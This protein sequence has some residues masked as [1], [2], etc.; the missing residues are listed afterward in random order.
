MI[1]L[2][3]VSTAIT[4]GSLFFQLVQRL[5]DYLRYQLIQ[6]FPRRLSKLLGPVEKL[7]IE[8]NG[9]LHTSIFPLTRVVVK[10]EIRH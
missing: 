4:V 1:I 9:Y 8:V 3:G 2:E 5:L 6:R 10:G 7:I